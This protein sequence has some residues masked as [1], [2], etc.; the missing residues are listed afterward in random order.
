MTTSYNASGDNNPRLIAVYPSLFFPY[1]PLAC[2]ELALLREL[3]HPNVINL[4][5]V[6]LSN[7]GVWLVLDFAEHDLVR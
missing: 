3:D 1:P 4:R 7:A 5:K 6:F 2:R